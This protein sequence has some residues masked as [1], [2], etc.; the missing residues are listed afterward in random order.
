M[1]YHLTKKSANTVD[2][3]WNSSS[4][5]KRTWAA[6]EVIPTNLFITRLS[7]NGFM[8]DMT[9]AMVVGKRCYAANPFRPDVITCTF[10]PVI[11]R[12]T[13]QY[14]AYNCKPSTPQQLMQGV[15]ITPGKRWSDVRRLLN[16]PTSRKRYIYLVGFF[17]PNA[18]DTKILKPTFSLPLRITSNPACQVDIWGNVNCSISPC[19]DDT[20][21]FT[22]IRPGGVG[23]VTPILVGARAECTCVGDPKLISSCKCQPSQNISG[24]V[25]RRDCCDPRECSQCNESFRP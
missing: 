7:G 22:T 1:T 8:L 10:N 25:V 17:I 13:L 23:T 3:Y 15:L 6:N 4:R 20:Q 21:F 14:R 11:S 2:F 5:L 9:K 16:I 19:D 24:Q 12:G 18:L